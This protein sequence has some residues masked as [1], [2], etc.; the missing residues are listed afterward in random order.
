MS[1]NVV[2]VSDTSAVNLETLATQANLTVG[3]WLLACSMNCVTSSL[4][5]LQERIYRQYTFSRR[6]VFQR[7]G[8][9]KGFELYDSTFPIKMLAKAT[10]ILVPMAVPCI[11]Q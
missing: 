10:A 2:S 1:R 3:W 4:F 11:F 5:I 6:V 8:L 9:N 7:L